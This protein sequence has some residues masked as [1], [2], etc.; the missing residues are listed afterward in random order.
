MQELEQFFLFNF[1]NPILLGVA[2]V[3]A[4]CFLVIIGFQFGIYFRLFFFRDKSQKNGVPSISVVVCGRNAG[5]KFEKNLPHI[6]EQKHPD[7]EVI[8]VNDSSYDNTET[9]L[10]MLKDVYPNMYVTNVRQNEKHLQSKKLPL[11]LGIKA[12]QNEYVVVTD[13]E[14]IP[15][16]DKWLEKLASSFNNGKKIVVGYS[17]V[18]DKGGLI[19]KLVSF[20]NVLYYK[21]TFA[22]ALSGM[23]F[24]GYGKNLAYNKSLFFDNKGYASN[25]G[26]VFGDDEIFINEVADKSNYA[27][28]LDARTVINYKLSFKR[29]L[30][31]DMDRMSSKKYFKKGHRLMLKFEN[32]FKILFWIS[33]AFFA[34]MHIENENLLI[35]ALVL[36]AFYVFVSAIVNISS[37]IKFK[38]YRLLYLYPLFELVNLIYRVVQ[39]VA[40]RFIRERTLVP[41]IKSRV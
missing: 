28:N 9:V 3:V 12:A 5:A 19:S 40:S 33:S 4:I 22:Y 29:F 17:S 30:K 32:L 21:R 27:I 8:V 38:E 24:R 7:F 11:T 10:A 37:I 23:P 16:D 36:P 20:V 39:F 6:L 35:G 31:E 1:E 34:Y 13:P 2:I 26:L 25:Y 18:R 15:E 41:R 14:F